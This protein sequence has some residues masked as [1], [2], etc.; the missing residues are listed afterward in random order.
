[1]PL[2]ACVPEIGICL[3]KYHA[4][5]SERQTCYSLGKKLPFI[6]LV[7]RI[8]PAGDYGIQTIHWRIEVL[9]V[10]LPA[11]FTK[12]AVLQRPRPAHDHQK[13]IQHE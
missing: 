1:V 9:H 13:H 5:T 8:S 12:R 2:A 3:T 11:A 10:P 7:T 4:E 6:H